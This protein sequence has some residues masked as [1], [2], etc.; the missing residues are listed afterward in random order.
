MYTAIT[1][2]IK[3]SV[4]AFYQAQQSNPLVNR[5]IH[6]YRVYIENLSPETVQLLSRHWVIVDSNGITREVEGDGV[7]GKQPILNPG[8]NHE[9]SSWSPL[10]TDMGKM[11]GTFTMRS[12]ENDRMF[13]VNIP[14]FQ[15]IA[16]F[17]A[18]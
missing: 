5:Y 9:Y 16:P 7:I 14:V 3:I 17:K 2:N 8:Q 6:A 15:L 18:N 4:E 13:K 12:L 10:A 1:H 11:Y